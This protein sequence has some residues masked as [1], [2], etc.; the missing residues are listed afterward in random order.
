MKVI[1]IGHRGFLGSAVGAHLSGLGIDW[2]GVDRDSYPR[3]RGTSADV[4]INANGSSDRRLAVTDPAADFALNVASTMDTLRDFAI[5]RY[6]L[7]SSIEVYPN[8]SDRRGSSEE[9]SI[10]PS[11]LTTYGLHKW[12]AELLVRRHA[13]Q[14][15]I[16]RVG[17]LVGPGLRKNSIFDLLE[18][19]KLFVDP[20]SALQ[21]I[22]TRDVARAVWILM[23]GDDE[24]VNVC[25]A[26]QVVL[27]DVARDLDVGLGP[28]LYELPK[29]CSDVPI[30]RLRAH[31]HPRQSVDA[32]R[33]FI[34]EW[35]ARGA[36]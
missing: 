20:R 5:D 15:L 26:G 30:D 28:E 31:M 8:P 34:R 23:D 16:L 33:D 17:P 11:H 2:V 10:D 32:V 4:L 29:Q 24:I 6:V 27:E 21:Y 9:A 25:G 14:A 3:Y 12:M 13:R 1:L 18:R 22:D 36:T 35:T 19:R 7:V